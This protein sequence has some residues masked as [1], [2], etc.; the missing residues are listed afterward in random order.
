MTSEVPGDEGGVAPSLTAGRDCGEKLT[1]L[2]GLLSAVSRTLL[3]L[4]GLCVCSSRSVIIFFT[5][6]CY[7]WILHDLGAL[8]ALCVDYKGLNFNPF[9][10]NRLLAQ[11]R[12]GRSARQA[13]SIGTGVRADDAVCG[14]VA[15]CQRV[16]RGEDTRAGLAKNHG[17]VVLRP[18]T[19]EKRKGLATGESFSC[20]RIQC[21]RGKGW[22]QG[23][24]AGWGVR[25]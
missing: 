4:S 21:A 10:I 19:I 12:R 7:V 25:R 2:S 5:H 20:F 9:A 11:T 24:S 3:H 23:K 16:R 13:V 8:G 1:P 22:M 14:C 18:K 6:N 17:S 15:P